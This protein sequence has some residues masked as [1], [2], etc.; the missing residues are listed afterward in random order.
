MLRYFSLANWYLASF[1]KN[2]PTCRQEWTGLPKV[3]IMLKSI[4]ECLYKQHRDSTQVCDSKAKTKREKNL[5]IRA[6]NLKVI[7]KFEDLCTI[8]VVRTSY[9]RAAQNSIYASNFYF[10]MNPKFLLGFVSGLYMFAIVFTFFVSLY[11]EIIK[12]NQNDAE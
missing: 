6:K 9:L 8:P 4:I 3:N 10:L 2:C 12:T 11:C 7:Q 1:R 5:K